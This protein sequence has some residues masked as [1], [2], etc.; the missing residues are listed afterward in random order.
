MDNSL[1]ATI[2][3]VIKHLAGKHNQKT[4][5][6]HPFQGLSEE[7]DKLIPNQT[8]SIFGKVNTNLQIDGHQINIEIRPE[9]QKELKAKHAFSSCIQP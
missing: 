7:V 5:G 2:A 8:G 4:H 1:V 9:N 3:E 6:G